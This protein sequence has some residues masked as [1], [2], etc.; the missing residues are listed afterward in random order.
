MGFTPTTTT[1]ALGAAVLS[2]VALVL[3]LVLLRSRASTPRQ[4][5]N[6]SSASADP[7][8]RAE[9]ITQPLPFAN[10]TAATDSPSVSLRAAQ[11]TDRGRVRSHN[12]DDTLIMDLQNEDGQVRSAL[13]A[14]ADGVGGAQKGEVASRTAIESVIQA[15]RSDPFFTDGEYLK[16]G[17]DEQVVIE[18]LRNA[19]LSANREVYSVR[20]NQNVDMGT[21]MVLALV[22]GSTAY[23]A[24]VGDSRAYLLRDEEIR[25]ITQDH[26]L[27]ERMVTSGQITRAEARLHPRRNLI[28]RS[29]GADPH[30]EVDLFV[31]TLKPGD[32]LLLCSDGLSGPVSDDALLHLS[33]RE[34]NVDRACR[35]M[36]E[37][38]NQAGGTDNISVVLAEVVAS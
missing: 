31:E 10:R 24:N 20:V 5:A 17:A 11:R 4:G 8:A 26:S 38:A 30:V 32:R 9:E 22:M 1:L 15:L 28:F 12:E 13:Y 25:Q 37:A 3:V 18:V 35:S 6:H 16:G 21:T 29:L 23:V 14:I 34:P 7:V 36:I 2:L 19:V 33:S 27:V